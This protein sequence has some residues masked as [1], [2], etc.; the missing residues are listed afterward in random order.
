M[1][2][3]GEQHRDHEADTNQFQQGRVGLWTDG[4]IAV[5]KTMLDRQLGPEYISSRPSPGGGT[6]YYLEGWKAINLANEVFGF[7]G[8]SS[9]IKS[10]HED[11]VDVKETGKIDVGISVV[12]RVTLKDGTFHEDIGFGHVENARNKYMALSK[13][14]KEATTDAT[15]RALR[16]FGNSVGNCLHDN[17]YRRHVLRMSVPT[18]RFDPTNL[19]RAPEIAAILEQQKRK[20]NIQRT[21]EEKVEAIAPSS[22]VQQEKSVSQQ[23]QDLAELPMARQNCDPNLSDMRLATNTSAL[24]TND[25]CISRECDP[26]NRKVSLDEMS[27]GSDLIEDYNEFDDYMIQSDDLDD[28][29]IAAFDGEFVVRPAVSNGARNHTQQQQSQ[30]YQYQSNQL[31][32][33]SNGNGILANSRRQSE[34]KGDSV[35]KTLEDLTTDTSARPHS[36][37]EL[38]KNSVLHSPAPTASQEADEDNPP[39]VTQAQAATNQLATPITEKSI[40]FFS[41]RVAE[42]VQNDEQLDDKALFDV[43]FQSP[44]IRKT[45]DQSVSRPIAR[46][47]LSPRVNYDNP[48]LNTN[49]MV[50]MPPSSVANS[51]RHLLSMSPNCSNGIKRSMTVMNEYE[52]RNMEPLR[53]SSEKVLNSSGN[54]T[55]SSREDSSKRLKV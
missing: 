44:S 18:G 27:F 1:A 42:A 23:R 31:Q 9:E 54:A 32:I 25:N 10:I 48:R 55:D 30:S 7:N 38:S 12:V 47:S 22:V 16:C 21:A 2:Y 45:V 5:L 34:E 20:S 51:G 19:H 36:P 41:A 35:T 14:K 17:T 6:A 53:E 11:Y 4:E 39:G 24:A 15:K 26:A 49:R 13:C 50:G 52:K 3:Q 46:S 29:E 43:S 28:F 33:P 40:T 8:W 37:T